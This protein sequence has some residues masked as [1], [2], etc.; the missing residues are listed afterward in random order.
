VA[1][2]AR[3]HV[4]AAPGPVLKNSPVRIFDVTKPKVPLGEVVP[5][6]GFDGGLNVGGR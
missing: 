1:V 5:F 3:N 6:A 4:V 2:G